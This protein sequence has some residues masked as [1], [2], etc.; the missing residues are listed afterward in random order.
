MHEGRKNE[1][2]Q[3]DLLQSMEDISGGKK[4]QERKPL[5]RRSRDSMEKKRKDKDRKDHFSST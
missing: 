4:K 3:T 5:D 2:D 1:C